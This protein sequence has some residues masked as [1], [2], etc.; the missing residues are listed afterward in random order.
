MREDRRLGPPPPQTLYQHGRSFLFLALAATVA[1]SKGIADIRVYENG[2]VALN[3]PFS[4]ARFNTRTTHPVF[5]DLFARL[6][7]EALEVEVRIANPFELMTKG[8]V[9]A[10]LEPRDLAA[11]P[12]T[13]SC[14]S[15]S[16]VGQITKRLG[17]ASFS[18]RH[19]GRCIPCIWRRAAVK[20]A[21]AEHDDT[22]IWD[23]VPDEQWPRFLDRGHL[24]PLLDL[25]RACRNTLATPDDELLDLCPELDEIG[26][27]TLDERLA[28]H[29]R[30]SA[31]V[32]AWFEDN[33]D[34]LR[35]RL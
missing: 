26:P 19:C 12:G 27:A 25:Y 15:Y 10:G 22:Y 2:P 18:G 20:H 17:L 3:A 29:R 28:L 21:G 33:A 16:K 11:I 7:R 4:E 9:L 1:I 8:E 23:E 32:A 35:Y 5:L 14:W 31:E 30:Y 34:R 24:T 13:N 6:L